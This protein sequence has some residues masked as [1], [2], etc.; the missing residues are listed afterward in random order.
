M[1]R[2]ALA[3]VLLAFGCRTVI[4][5][6]VDDDDDTDT[7][8]AATDSGSSGAG[9]T[10]SDAGDSTAPTTADSTD[11]N[12]TTGSNSDTAAPTTETASDGSSSSGASD[13]NP[14]PQPI[15]GA[16]PDGLGYNADGDYE[17]CGPPCGGGDSCPDTETGNVLTVCVFNPES[18]MAPCQS[19]MCEDPEE[20][21]FAGTCMLPATHCAPL[22]STA[23][24]VCPDGMECTTNEVCRFPM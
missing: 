2:F 5:V 11:G 13:S 19:A 9:F 24:A 4:H 16:C 18:S 12:P 3:L 23:D 8:G 10:T 21:C 7:G 20:S 6:H 1:R 15:D 17:F 22:C 14:Y